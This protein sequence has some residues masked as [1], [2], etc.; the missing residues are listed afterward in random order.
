MNGLSKT[1][2]ILSSFFIN[3]LQCTKWHTI[4]TIFDDDR[5]H[6]TALKCW[7]WLCFNLFFFSTFISR[8]HWS[9]CFYAYKCFNLVWRVFKCDGSKSK[10]P[11]LYEKRL[12]WKRA[13]YVWGMKWSKGKRCKT[14][15]HKWTQEISCSF[16]QNHQL[17]DILYAVV[18][19]LWL[20]ISWSIFFFRDWYMKHEII[21][22]IV[23]FLFDVY[24][25]VSFFWILF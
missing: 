4:F 17:D 5:S 9:V 24:F 7:A 6:I 8:F 12:W 11:L 10:Q 18:P 2:F 1:H 22:K 21:I 20:M 3:N 19:I 23:G 16:I 13:N 14:E 15:N 25:F